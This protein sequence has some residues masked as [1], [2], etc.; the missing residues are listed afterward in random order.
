MRDRLIEQVIAE[1]GR[2]I[3]IVR[4]Q[5]PPDGDQVLLLLWTLVQPWISGAVID[6]RARLSARCGMQI[7]D[8]IQIFSTAP[9]DQPIQ[10]PETFRVVALEQAVMQRNSN[11]VE[12]SPMQE[13]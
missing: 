9:D 11:G 10:Q 12:P 8:H 5:P 7:K 6:V 1:H 2:L 13:R 4:R 3:A